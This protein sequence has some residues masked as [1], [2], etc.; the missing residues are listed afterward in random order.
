MNVIYDKNKIHP[1][2][3]ND[4]TK[5]EERFSFLQILRIFWSC[6]V[7]RGENLVIL[8]GLFM[9]LVSVNRPQIVSS[10]TI[11]YIN[12]ARKIPR[13]V[14]LFSLSSGNYYWC[15]GVIC[16]IFRSFIT[17]SFAPINHV[18]NIVKYY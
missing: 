13:K 1:S 3:P 18:M 6:F 12:D 5:R 10:Y 9:V 14:Y 4:K 15:F 2:K 7:V 11:V 8:T 17:D 16:K